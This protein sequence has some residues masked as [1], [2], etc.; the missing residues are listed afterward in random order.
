M[1]YGYNILFGLPFRY[2]AIYNITKL[3]SIATILAIVLLKHFL[4][5]L[6]K[7]EKKKK[8]LKILY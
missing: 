4:K 6:L 3:F 7:T 8:N 2:V 5:V 1:G